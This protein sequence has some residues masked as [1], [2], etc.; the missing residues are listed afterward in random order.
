MA[1][2]ELELKKEH[3]D[4]H[5]SFLDLDISIQGRSFNTS[6]YDKR[7]SFPFSI[8]RMPFKC[9]NMPS[10]IFYSTIGAEILRIGRASSTI[11]PFIKSAKSIIERMK[12]QGAQPK[13]LTDILKRTYGRHDVLKKFA[14]D[15][16][17][18][19]SSLIN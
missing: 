4:I 19:V 11:G 9:S 16:V 6:L 15:S 2:S 3:G 18:F 13:K 12:D 5:V 17:K 7:D 14:A 1:P 10:K 8:V